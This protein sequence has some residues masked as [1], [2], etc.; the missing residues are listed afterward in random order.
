MTWFDRFGRWF[1]YELSDFDFIWNIMMMASTRGV[2]FFLMMIYFGIKYHVEKR[3]LQKAVNNIVLKWSEASTGIVR[4]A[5]EDNRSIL[6]RLG[7]D[8][9]PDA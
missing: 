5:G 9:G 2:W 4:Y 7:K 3:R 6:E 8:E 1:R